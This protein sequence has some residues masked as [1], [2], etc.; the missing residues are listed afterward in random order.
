MKKRIIT[1]LMVICLLC[2]NLPAHASSRIDAKAAIMIDAS[3]GQIIYEQNAEQQLP[4]ASITKLLTVAV[5]HDELQQ[6]DITSTT[7]VKITPD[8]AA[9]SDNPS[10]S[11]IGLKSGQSYPVVELLNAAMVKSADGATAALA[12]AS[13]NSI[14]EFVIKMEQKATEIG[15]KKTKIINPTGLTNNEMGSL[16]SSSYPGNAENEMSAKDV[17]LLARYLIH[18]YPAILQVTSQKKANFLISKGDV[19]S[20]ANLN[21]MLP[22]GKYTIPGVT[23]NGLKTGTSDNAGACFVSTGRYQGHQIIT[24]VLHANGDNADNRFVQ[25]QKLYQMLKQNYQLQQIKLPNDVAYPQINHGNAKTLSTKPQSLSVWSNHKI[26]SYTVSQDF[27][28]NLTNNT[29][30]LEAP[31]KKGQRIGN[32]RLTSSQLKTVS[33]EPLIY[34]LYSNQTVVKAGFFGRLF[35]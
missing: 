16:K 35:N 8:I 3:T 34:P 4:I 33:N 20:F 17:A 2:F 1:I 5:I 29:Q 26:T 12:T 25:T 15:L 13:G 21:K 22:G 32:L 24:V 9:I 14:D 10:Y 27:T 11:S 19:K 31:I 7:K 6:H 23:I 28:N 30:T 18:S